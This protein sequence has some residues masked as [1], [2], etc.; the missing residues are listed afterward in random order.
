VAVL[1]SSVQSPRL[2]DSASQPPELVNVNMEMVP[3][4]TPLKQGDQVFLG[5]ER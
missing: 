4:D 3:A 2:A 5:D 1:P